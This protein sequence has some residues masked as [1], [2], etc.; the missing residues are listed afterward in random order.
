MPL[1]VLFERPRSGLA[2]VTLNNPDRLNALSTGMVSALHDALD[3]LAGDSRCRVVILTGAGR[4]FCSGLD[5]SEP[6]VAPTARD[7]TGAASGMRT[8]EFIA[9]LVPKMI[10]L[11]QP[12]I[13]AVNGPAVGGG[14]ALAAASD[15]R[16]AGLSASF[17][18]QF[19]RLGVSGCDIGVSYTLPKLIG[20]ARAAEL[21]YTARRIG[22][23]EA[24]RIGFVSE[25]VPDRELMSRAEEIASVMLS[26][27]PFALEMTKQVFRA[28]QDAANAAAAIAL[29]NRTQVL[30]GSGGDFAEAVAARSEG[31]APYWATEQDADGR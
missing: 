11:P 22:A 13:A 5:L 28:N 26:H 10:S 7:R 4:G 9:S 25:V 20:G 19:I 24:E 16:V 29:E 17:C 1:P 12:V 18:T 21:I 3:E 2:V 14:F 23:E 6:A 30:A 31:R 15:L 8:Q 27:S